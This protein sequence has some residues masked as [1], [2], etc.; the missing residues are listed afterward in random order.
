MKREIEVK[1]NVKPAGA[2]KED[3]GE[4]IEFICNVDSELHFDD[5]LADAMRSQVI[6]WQGQI[7]NNWD[8]FMSPDYEIPLTLDYGEALFEGKRGG[9]RA[10]TKEEIQA[11]A[12]QIIA[13]MTPEEIQEFVKTGEFPS[14]F[15]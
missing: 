12:A 11:S 9:K 3:K 7:R 5:L 2:E 13:Q 10:P 14:R 4:T 6:K 1:F 15:Q 8:K